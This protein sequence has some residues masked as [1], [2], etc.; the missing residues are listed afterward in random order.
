MIFVLRAVMVSLAFFVLVYSFLSMLV[1]LTWR[2]LHLCHLDKRI[3]ARSLFTLRVIPFAISAAVSLFLAM[4]SFLLLEGHSLDED[5]GT[6]ALGACALLILG[7]GIY[8]MLAAER[9]T[10]QVVSAC[11]ESAISLEHGPVI[12]AVVLARSITPL[13]LVGVRTPRILISASACKIL[14]DGEL[15]AAVRHETAHSR[16]RDNLK[17][18]ILNCLPF[19]GMASLEEAWREASE[20]AADDGAVSSRA[21]ALDLA[22]A[23]IKLAR[24]FPCQAVPELATGLMSAVGS[25]TSRVKRLMAWKESSAANPQRWRYVIGVTFIVVFGLAAKLGSALIL[26]HSLTERFVP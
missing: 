10:R 20:L 3:G 12:P 15:R 13:M 5:L 2:G 8:R 24:H 19:P 25:V 22:A 7:T 9:R 18:A 11:L 4:P 6:F 16:S 23:L 1:F 26:V 17:K 21:E 14:N